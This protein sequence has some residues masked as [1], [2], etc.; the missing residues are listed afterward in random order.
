MRRQ[1]AQ[2]NLSAWPNVE[3]I[4][5]SQTT[6]GDFRAKNATLLAHESTTCMGNTGRQTQL[7]QGCACDQ[8]NRQ[9]KNVG[10]KKKLLKWYCMN[11]TVSE[12]ITK[13]KSRSCTFQNQRLENGKISFVECQRDVSLN[14]YMS[15]PIGS[16]W[17]ANGCN[18]SC[19]K[20]NEVKRNFIRKPWCQ[21]L[22]TSDFCAIC[23]DKEKFFRKYG[24]VYK[25][26]R[27]ETKLISREQDCDG[28][29]DCKNKTDEAHC[30]TYYCKSIA[31]KVIKKKFIWRRSAVNV[32]KYLPCL[33]LNPHWKGLLQRTCSMKMS[34]GTF[35]PTLDYCQCQYTRK[36]PTIMEELSTENVTVVMLKENAWQMYNYS[37]DAVSQK[38]SIQLAMVL[39]DKAL[40]VSSKF[41]TY[42]KPNSNLTDFSQA[43]YNI[44]QRPRWCNEADAYDELKSKWKLFKRRYGISVVIAKSAAI[45]TWS[46]YHSDFLQD[47]LFPDKNP[48]KGTDVDSFQ[49]GKERGGPKPGITMFGFSNGTNTRNQSIKARVIQ[50][51]LN[52]KKKAV[53]THIRV[54]LILDISFAMISLLALI[55]AVILLFGFN[56]PS[57]TKLFIHKNL[58][59]ARIISTF[60]YVL[61]SWIERDLKKNRGICT[62]FMIFQY[63]TSMAT[64]SWMLVEGINLFNV[65]VL[66]FQT[67]WTNHKVYAAIGWGMFHKIS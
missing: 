14:C 6:C 18:Y 54:Q 60:I 22:S 44:L 47:I 41:S 26:C 59:V 40:N 56:V 32:T 15:P 38:R 48:L 9:W 43:I 3:T 55:I 35:W 58:F 8:D 65:I 12:S 46:L 25:M 42:R 7:R 29:N 1:P 10:M 37:V 52:V 53:D 20:E 39:I 34:G 51:K 2:K 63:C 28:V 36:E 21:S 45:K 67:R 49:V 50:V 17:L 5:T 31:E 61:G 23:P 57:T 11:C 4:A 66:V 24:S 30:S 16:S 27:D 62:T 33:H 64:F 19:T 13:F